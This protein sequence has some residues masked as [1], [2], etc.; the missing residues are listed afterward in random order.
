MGHMK[1]YRELIRGLPS[2]RLVCTFG[3]FQPPTA[4]HEFQVKAVKKLAEQY[5][6]DHLVLI[7]P[8]LKEEYLPADKKVQYMNLMFPV[9]NIKI[10]EGTIE[11]SLA[12]LSKKY[13]NIVL[14]ISE[15]LTEH[16]QKIVKKANLPSIEIISAG[17]TD[18]DSNKLCE[19]AKKG[20]YTKFKKG[21]PSSLRELDSRRLMNDIRQT[22]GLELVREEIKFTVDNIRDKYFKGEIYHIGEIVESD[23]TVYQII[24]RGSNHLLLQSEDGSKVSK[25][26][27][28]VKTSTREFML[29]EGVMQ[30]TGT[31]QVIPAP[32]S[33]AVNANGIKYK[34]FAKKLSNKKPIPEIDLD[35]LDGDGDHDPD[36]PSAQDQMAVAAQTS[37][38]K[39]EP[40]RVVGGLMH[41]PLNVTDDNHRRRKINYHLGEEAIDEVSSELLDR[42]KEK[43]KKSADDLASK[44]QYKKSTDRWSNVMKATGKQIEKTTA[45]IKKSLNKEEIVNEVKYDISHVRKHIDSM[46]PTVFKKLY[47]KSKEDM[48]STITSEEKQY[49]EE[50]TNPNIKLRSGALKH[51]TKAVKLDTEEGWEDHEMKDQKQP[52]WGKGTLPR[53][54]I[55]GVDN[56]NAAGQEPHPEEWENYKKKTV[57]EHVHTLQHTYVN[58]NS[59]HKEITHGDAFSLKIGKEH[60]QNI[61]DLEHGEHH[62]FNCMDGKEWHAVRHGDDVHFI[63][64]PDEMRIHTN[65]HPKVPHA[66]FTGEQEYSENERPAFQTVFASGQTM[67]KEQ[68]EQ[69]FTDK[70]VELDDLSDEEINRMVDSIKDEN[71][72]MDAYDDAEFAVVDDESGEEIPE[73]DKAVKEETINEVLSRSERM[74]AR[75][76]FAK[77]KVKRERSVKLALKRSSSSETINKRARRL[78]I[79]LMKKKLLRG[80]SASSLSVGEK[81]RIEKQISKR[82]S[83]INRIAMKLVS[84]VRQIEKTRLSH[85]KYTK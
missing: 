41:H 35:D 33:P 36:H 31:D 51:H 60:H 19:S 66:Q 65:Y 32:T 47:G 68:E 1:N 80:R 73:Q 67:V 63:H 44:G 72:I 28:D 46:H 52:V 74:R 84:K 50:P 61:F 79:G 29:K 39:A 53:D 82:K 18:P 71:D 48:K 17:D 70:Q 20:D 85:H 11:K 78:A 54:S 5:R 76:R 69:N 37:I 30:P 8:S 7:S 75:V 57:K 15:D 62:T 22:M 4:A 16:Y 43:A 12:E 40:I 6:S 3:E 23:D 27:Q 55:K 25:W 45:N 38:D 2:N 83:I 21:L 64:H 56:V 49:E 34:D 77:S 14:V 81:E 10:T 26:I 9:T 42:Y 59:D 13:K 24:K 58:H